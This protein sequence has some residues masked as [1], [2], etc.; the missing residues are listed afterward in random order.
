MTARATFIGAL[1]Q[2]EQADLAW[3]LGWG[4]FWFLFDTLNIKN[5]FAVRDFW[6]FLMIVSLMIISVIAIYE[7][8]NKNSCPKKIWDVAHLEDIE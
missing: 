3:V 1:W 6:M 8:G 5:I 4:S 2:L 7:I